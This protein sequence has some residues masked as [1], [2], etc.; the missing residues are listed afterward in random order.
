[1]CRI[2]IDQLTKKKYKSMAKISQIL[3]SYSLLGLIRYLRMRAM[4]RELL[5]TGSCNCCGDCCRKINLEGE[6]GWLRQE[7]D[8]HSVVSDHP[9]YQRFQITGRDDQGFLQFSCNCLTKNNI[10]GDHANRLDICRNF[11]D[12]SLHFCG[13]KLPANCGFQ[14]TEVR[15]FSKFLKDEMG[16]KK[17]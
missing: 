12:K 2:I 17:S 4:K 3:S 14:I 15:P 9:E 8:F 1:M 6:Y 16:A 10:C 13:G 11:P 7:K 5:I